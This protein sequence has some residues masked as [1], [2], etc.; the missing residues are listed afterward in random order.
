VTARIAGKI[1]DK[2]KN[3]RDEIDTCTAIIV[4]ANIQ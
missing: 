4:A 1:Q 3:T 2:N